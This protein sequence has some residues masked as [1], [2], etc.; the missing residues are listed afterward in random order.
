LSNPKLNAL[1]LEGTAF[2]DEMARMIARSTSVSSL[3]LGATKLTRRGLEHLSSMKQL[4]SLDLWATSLEGRDLEL[5]RSLPRLEYVSI[6]GHDGSKRFDAAYLVDL[7]RSL[8]SLTRLW[9]DGVSI[10]QAQV[11]A[12][13]ERLISVRVTSA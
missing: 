3:D 10:D 13:K 6:G 7:F 4:R 5:L 2:D 12:L 1:D 8:P 9:L 11:D